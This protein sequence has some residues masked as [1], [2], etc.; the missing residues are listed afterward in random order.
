MTSS[1]LLPKTYLTT[2]N[3][4][5]PAGSWLHYLYYQAMVHS[6][7]TFITKNNGDDFATFITQNIGHDFIT[8]ITRNI[9]PDYITSVT[10]N[11]G[12]KFITSITQGWFITL[13]LLL[14]RKSVLN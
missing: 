13:L 6:F 3:L 8:F 12:N 1:P 9:G 5:Y 14:P 11:F 2:F 7:I 4:N 10:Q